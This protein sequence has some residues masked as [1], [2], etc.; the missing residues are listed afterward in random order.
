M[1]TR[2]KNP[3]FTHSSDAYSGSVLGIFI[4]GEHSPTEV[5]NALN[6]L[7]WEELGFYSEGRFSFTQRALQNIRL[8]SNFLDT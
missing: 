7:N 4:R 1:K 6:S 2:N 8:P 5:A 3:F